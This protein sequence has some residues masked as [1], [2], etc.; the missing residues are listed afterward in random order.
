MAIHS[1]HWMVLIHGALAN[2]SV[3]TA[4][5]NR[6]LPTGSRKISSGVKECCSPNS[7]YLASLNTPLI[8]PIRIRESCY[9]QWFSQEAFRAPTV[10]YPSEFNTLRIGCKF[11]ARRVWECCEAI[12]TVTCSVVF[13][14]RLRKLIFLV[15]KY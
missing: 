2:D 7:R 12:E 1:S 3:R 5:L 4:V 13:L 14:L 15:D 6:N 10:P 9:T 8:G 11:A